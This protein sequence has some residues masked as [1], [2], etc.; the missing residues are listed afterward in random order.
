MGWFGEAER[1][2]EGEEEDLCCGEEGVRCGELRLWE[3]EQQS[4]E[5][6]GC[7]IGISCRLGSVSLRSWLLCR[8]LL[9]QLKVKRQSNHLFDRR[10][11]D[12]LSL[13][14]RLNCLASVVGAR[15]MGNHAL[16]LTFF[17][18]SVFFSAALCL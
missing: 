10:L 14:A 4:A 15:C 1:E 12:P 16:G 9:G 5:F 8:R 13:S 11:C 18:S 17:E 2:R 6:K 7:A 3:E